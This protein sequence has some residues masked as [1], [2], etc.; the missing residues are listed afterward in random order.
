MT[1]ILITSSGTMALAVKYGYE[2]NRRICGAVFVA[3]GLFTAY[4]IWKYRYNTPHLKSAV[5]EKD[6]VYIIQPN[7]KKIRVIIGPCLDK[8][9]YLF[10]YLLLY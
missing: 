4:C 9:H 8:N 1:F 2:K 7:K 5:D 3:I 6:N 10:V